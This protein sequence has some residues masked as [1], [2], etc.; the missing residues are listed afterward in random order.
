MRVI[1]IDDHALFRDGLKGL[2]EQ[3]SIE[4]AGVAADR[5]AAL[6]FRTLWTYTRRRGNLPT[7]YPLCLDF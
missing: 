6:P 2:L 1:I 7:G 5:G 3:R 4:V